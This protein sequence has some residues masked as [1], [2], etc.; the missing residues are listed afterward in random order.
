MSRVD[1]LIYH[2]ARPMPL[3]TLMLR[4][5]LRRWPVGSYEARLR[6]GA[7]LRPHYGWCMYYAAAEAKALGFLAVTVAEMGVA[8]GYGLLCLCQHRKE[9]E[10][11]LG[12]EIVLVGF[13][14]GTGLP[15]SRDPRDLLYF[16]P[17]GSFEMDRALLEK[18]LD[19]KAQLIVGDIAETAQGW[20]PR[21]D[22]PL[23]AVLFDLDLYTS[24]ANALSILTKQDVLPRVWC[25]FDDICGGP[26]NAL[27]DSI[28]ER[29]A[30]KEFNQKPERRTLND[31]LSPA[32]V[33]KNMVP[34][35]WHQ[36]IYLSHR[37]THPLYNKS[38]F[39]PGQKRVIMGR[40]Q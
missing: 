29:E 4:S 34:E 6:A 7:V 24:T 35:G 31:H 32:Y 33:F 30:I 40:P 3:R 16:W 23:G 15:A 39:A 25:Y 28:G 9:I 20:N 36:H 14:A 1:L 17:A 22:A 38:P 8:T 27:T 21:P 19:G 2:A 26:E 13:D 37:L 12:I 10:K 11:A 18:Q 5:L